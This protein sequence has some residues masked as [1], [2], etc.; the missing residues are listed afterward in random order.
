MEKE[1]RGIDRRTEEKIYCHSYDSLVREMAKSMEL[2][3]DKLFPKEGDDFNHEDINSWIGAVNFQKDQSPSIEFSISSDQGKS[4]VHFETKKIESIQDPDKATSKEE[5][6][7]SMALTEAKMRTVSKIAED[8]YPAISSQI[9]EYKKQMELVRDEVLGNKKNNESL[10]EMLNR[11]VS[12]RG[13]L[14]ASAMVISS[15]VLSACGVTVQPV[16]GYVPTSTRPNK[17]TATEVFTKPFPSKTAEPTATPTKTAT[18]MIEAT[19]TQ[20]PLELQTKIEAGFDVMNL[21]VITMEDITSGKLA[22]SERQLIASGEIKVDFSEASIPGYYY[23]WDTG[24]RG[25]IDFGLNQRTNS[26]LEAGLDIAKRPIKTIS[27]SRMEINGKWIIV[28]GQAWANMNKSMSLV[29]FGI[30]DWENKVTETTINKVVDEED[31]F[32]M[33][34]KI[35][36]PKYRDVGLYHVD[37]N[38]GCDFR[39]QAEVVSL[40]DKYGDEL[41]NLCE[42]SGKTGVVSEEIEKYLLTFFTYPW[43]R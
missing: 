22:E 6:L 11:I 32:G 14:L 24:E 4:E 5:L 35:D 17:A 3:T 40:Y 15:L 42:Q 34:C 41:K 10:D 27:L 13:M 23:E 37:P 39:A 8:T 43:V 29:H 31:F 25:Y 12:R 36:N 26:F 38:M 19:P 28:M 30:G 33:M 7:Y 21:P 18:P 16:E 9:E 2:D 1:N 20:K